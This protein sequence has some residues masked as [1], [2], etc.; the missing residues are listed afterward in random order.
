MRKIARLTLT[1]GH[2]IWYTNVPIARYQQGREEGSA[3]GAAVE[4]TWGCLGTAIRSG[5]EGKRGRVSFVRSRAPTAGWSRAVPANETRP[6]FPQVRNDAEDVSPALSARGFPNQLPVR[7]MTLHRPVESCRD[8]N[9][10]AGVHGC[11]PDVVDRC[12]TR[13]K[14]QDRASRSRTSKNGCG[15]KQMTSRC[16]D[17]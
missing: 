17:E 1:L 8:D 12:A 14:T 5:S 13:R 7:S 10:A 15:K 6:L 4:Q 16:Y 2:S 11:R 9:P 3:E